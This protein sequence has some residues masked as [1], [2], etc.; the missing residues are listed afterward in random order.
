MGIHLMVIGKTRAYVH[1]FASATACTSSCAT[2]MSGT[3]AAA[4][5]AAAAIDFVLF[6]DSRR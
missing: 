2:D 1:A 5:A 4:A 3:T 6:H